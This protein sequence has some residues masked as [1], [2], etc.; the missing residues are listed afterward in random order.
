[1]QL[2][3]ANARHQIH[4]STFYQ[5]QLE[6][7]DDP[8]PQRLLASAKVPIKATALT[9]GLNAPA[10]VMETD[11][12]SASVNVPAAAR[13]N[14]K[15]GKVTASWSPV[16]VG[17]VD[18]LTAQLQFIKAPQEG[19]VIVNLNTGYH[20]DKPIV[21]KLAKFAGSAAGSWNGQK[22]PDRTIALERTPAK[23]RAA[24]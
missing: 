20:A 10:E 3:G 16:T 6:R 2:F 23:C 22:S 18:T 11:N 24:S 8:N 12:F 14:A 21:V 19:F 1:M 15:D 13:Q 17:P 5:L 7:L 9:L 4:S